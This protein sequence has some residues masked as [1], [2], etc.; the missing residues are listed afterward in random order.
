MSADLV[1]AEGIRWFRSRGLLAGFSEQL[2]Q[3]ARAVIGQRLELSGMRWAVAGAGAI[4]ALCCREAGGRP[5]NF[6]HARHN[7]AGAA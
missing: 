2:W 6:C 5:G 1:E 7:R 4:I 3:A